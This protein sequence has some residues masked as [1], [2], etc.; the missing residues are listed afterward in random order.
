MQEIVYDDEKAMY[1]DII[2]SISKKL[3]FFN[4]KY[5]VYRTWKEFPPDLKKLIPD[6][7][8]ILKKGALPDITVVY[9]DDNHNRHFLIIEVKIGDLTI[10][11]IAQA[12]MYGDIFN[13]DSVLVVS[14]IKFRKN[15]TEFDLVNKNFLKCANGSQI[16]LCFMKYR[17]LQLQR[18]YP[19]DG[20]LIK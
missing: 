3:A 12:K 6:A 7:V 9:E 1:P 11:D 20:G 13:A 18:V 10:K 2:D 17:Q 19:N 4:Y 14:L 5:T 8:N 15:Y 16:Y